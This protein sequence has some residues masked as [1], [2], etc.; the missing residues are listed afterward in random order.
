MLALVVT[1][2]RDRSQAIA[3]LDAALAEFEVEGVK[4]N[5][6]FLRR[7]LVSEAFG[8]GRHHTTFAEAFAKTREALSQ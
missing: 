2:G 8:E 4:T 3:L 6:P 5:I 1:V 7:M